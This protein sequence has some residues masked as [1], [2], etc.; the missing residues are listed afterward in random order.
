[1]TASG[2]ET[3]ICVRG[4]TKDYGRGRG[5]FDVC[6]EVAAGEVLGGIHGA[7]YTGGDSLGAAL[8]LGRLAGIE[9]AKA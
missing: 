6:L 5:V 7:S 3:A 2:V 9:I 8:A 1:M 4:L